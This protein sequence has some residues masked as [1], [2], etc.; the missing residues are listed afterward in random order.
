MGRLWRPIEG[1]GFT[2][3]RGARTSNRNIDQNKHG[4]DTQES[5]P[6]SFVR[7]TVQVRDFEAQ[8][9]N[10]CRTVTFCKENNKII[11]FG[12]FYAPLSSAKPM[13]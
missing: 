4:K 1:I 12:C 9:A 5:F 6:G 7:S 11:R 2:C 10:K 8:K 13:V 3:A